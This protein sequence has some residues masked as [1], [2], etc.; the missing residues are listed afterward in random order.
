MVNP[1]GSRINLSI[2]NRPIS[3]PKRMACCCNVIGLLLVMSIMIGL[4]CKSTFFR[5]LISYVG[6]KNHKKRT[7]FAF[8][9]CNLLQV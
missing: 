6:D 2:Q 5:L 9:C 4:L 1:T 7:F 3:V 8:F